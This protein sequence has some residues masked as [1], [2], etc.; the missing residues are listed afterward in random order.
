MKYRSS[1]PK[2]ARE[3]VIERYGNGSK[4]RAKYVLNGAVVGE[5]WFHEGGELEFERSLKRGKQHGRM[6]RWD[7]PGKLLS[8]EP[9]K[10]GKPHGLAK[11]W[12]NDGRLIGSYEMKHGTGIDLWWNECGGSLYLSEIHCLRDGWPHGFVGWLNAGGTLSNECYWIA[13]KK[14]GVERD[15]NWLGR[16]RRGYPKYYVHNQQVTRRHYIK[17][18]ASDPT[19]PKFD[20][21]DNTPKRKFPPEVR[22]A[23]RRGQ[24]RR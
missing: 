11:Q 9:Y 2:N 23:I 24:E 10:N 3:R 20:P 5:R 1:I 6:Y 8:V 19:L 21:A 18:C 4:K 15:W 7:E 14:H 12:G 16:L 13:G 17:T 22:A